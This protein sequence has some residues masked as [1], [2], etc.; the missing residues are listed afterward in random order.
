M[1]TTSSKTTPVISPI[2]FNAY[3]GLPDFSA[4]DLEHRKLRRQYTSLAVMAEAEADRHDKHSTLHHEWMQ[5]AA[6]YH[7]L[8]NL[9]SSS[10]CR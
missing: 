9:H 10:F 5:V 8:A 3:T 2:P 7:G 4:L 6:S 1:A